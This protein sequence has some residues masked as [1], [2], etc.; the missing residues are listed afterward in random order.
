MIFLTGTATTNGAH[1]SVPPSERKDVATSVTPA[2]KHV[3]HFSFTTEQTEQ[4]TVE[5]PNPQYQS[6]LGPFSTFLLAGL[7]AG[8]LV[9]HMFGDPHVAVQ[10]TAK[11]AKPN[12][13]PHRTV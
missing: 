10:R 5:V 3:A 1:A 4:V 9:R 12:S 8:V 2:Q 11:S 6:L 13:A 7:V